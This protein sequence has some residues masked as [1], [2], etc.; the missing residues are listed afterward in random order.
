[1]KRV[2]LVED[3]AADVELVTEAMERH[4]ALIRLEHV[5][6]GEAAWRLLRDRALQGPG[7]LPACI[8]LDMVMGA[9]DGVWLL[10][11]MRQ[12]AGLRDIPVIVLSERADAVARAR[13][14]PN[15]VGAMEKPAED[16]ERRKLVN[17]VLR[18]AGG[19]GVSA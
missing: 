2:L 9:Q 10:G 1:M 13:E 8:L 16:H 4:A 11:R 14:F 17:A 5:A 7:K 19:M 12:F 6:S 18:L 3:D 15:V